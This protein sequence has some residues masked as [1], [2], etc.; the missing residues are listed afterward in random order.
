MQIIP[1]TAEIAAR[2]ERLFSEKPPVSTRLWAILD[3]TIQGRILVDDPAQPTY[4]I[5]Q[6]LTEGTIFPG[7]EL[8][9]PILKEAFTILRPYQELMVCL[10]PGDPLA[11]ALPAQP[12]YEGKAI[13]FTDRSPDIDLDRL[14]CL[15]SGYHIQRINLEIAQKLEGVGYSVTMYGSLERAVQNMI[16]Y[17]LM[18]GET[19]VC[20]AETVPLSRGVAEMSVDTAEAYRQKG[21]ATVTC[22]WVIRECE[23]LGYQ[24]LWIAAQ[25][26]AA[27][28]ALARRLGFQTEQLFNVQSW[29]ATTNKLPG[30][31]GS[32]YPY[33]PQCT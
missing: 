6:D 3:G 11:S 12:D 4:A 23:A 8:T 25:Q 26:N 17:C 30:V 19:I 18:Q 28:V 7:G 10:W 15:P 32:P 31:E 20:E 5:L 33:N 1:F 16:G 21:L 24:T 22:A 27:S 29:S 9:A 2:L 13:Q 14:A